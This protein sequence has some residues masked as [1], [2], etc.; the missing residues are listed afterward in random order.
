MKKTQIIEV[1]ETL[2]N[3]LKKENELTISQAIEFLNEQ[4]YDEV[5]QKLAETRLFDRIKEHIC[6]D[7]NAYDLHAIARSNACDYDLLRVI[8]NNL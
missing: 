6:D 5:I 8:V 7:F 2:T 4:D 3:E 1:L